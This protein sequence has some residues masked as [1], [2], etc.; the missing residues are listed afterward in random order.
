MQVIKII[1]DWCWS[2][3]LEAVAEGPVML[4]LGTKSTVADLC[5]RHREQVENS[6]AVV[7]MF[8]V[9][10][11]PDREDKPKATRVKNEPRE[12]KKPRDKER[13]PQVANAKGMFD[14]GVDDCDREFVSPQGAGRHRLSM[15]QVPGAYANVGG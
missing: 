12:P 10:R 13:K 5:K 9:G 3:A 1:C 15:H 6:E 2:E 4:T 7:A 11:R 8:H 14:C